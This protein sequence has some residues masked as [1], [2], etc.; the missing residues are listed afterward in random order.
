MYNAFKTAGKEAKLILHQDA[1]NFIYGLN[2]GDKLYDEIVNR[3]LC[4]YLY[5]EENG[6]EDM[7]E[8]SVQSNVDGSFSFYDTF[9]DTESLK[10]LSDDRDETKIYSNSFEDF[11]NEYVDSYKVIARYYLEQDEKHV[12]VFDL[13][14]DNEDGLT[15]I[16]SCEIHVDLKT[17]DTDM[18]NM[19]VTAV[20]LDTDENG[21]PF[22]AYV[23]GND[24]G[25]LLP[26]KT[27][28]SYEI[29]GGHEDAVIHEFVQSATDVKAI[30]YGWTNLLTP[31]RGK[32]ASEYKEKSDIKEDTY[33]GYNIY[34]KPT[35][36]TLAPG[37]KL[38]LA[39][40]AQDPQRVLMDEVENDDTPYFIDDYEAP[41]YSFTVDEGSLAV[42]INVIK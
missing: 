38:K 32:S 20:L 15:F 31:G 30:A 6:A 26:K 39:L 2:I 41:Y 5:G 22:K 8:L 36:Y 4:H 29:G 12:K 35:V 34:L 10:L 28:G 9:P 24:L 16:G 13:E 33:Y 18:D 23:T 27:V 37:H 11:Y 14:T 7:P 21:D 17:D 42:K 19:M 40:L 1:H 3:W 25:D